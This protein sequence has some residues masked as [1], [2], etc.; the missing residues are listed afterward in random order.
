M[1]YMGLINQKN[2]CPDPP[3][4]IVI[5]GLQMKCR[6]QRTKVNSHLI[7]QNNTPLLHFNMTHY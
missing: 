2:V 3:E 5:S 1:T 7:D 4:A 6:F